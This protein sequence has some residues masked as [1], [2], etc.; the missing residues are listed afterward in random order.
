MVNNGIENRRPATRW[1]DRVL[2][3]LMMVLGGLRVVIAIDDDERWGAEASIAAIMTVLGFALA[4][5]PIRW[6]K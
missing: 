4:L 6:R 5:Y 1:D 2:G 3:V